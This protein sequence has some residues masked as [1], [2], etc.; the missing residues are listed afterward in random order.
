MGNCLA[1]PLPLFVQGF[2]VTYTAEDAAGNK[3]VPVVREVKVVDPCAPEQVMC[4]DLAL[5]SVLKQN[6]NKE[7]VQMFSNGGEEQ[8][9][10]PYVPEPDTDPPVLLFRGGCEAPACR[11]VTT[12]TGIRVQIHT[13]TVGEPFSEPGTPL[14][15]PSTLLM[16][17]SCGN[18]EKV[19]YASLPARGKPP[20][21]LL[22]GAEASDNRDG[23]VTHAISRLYSPG[24]VSTSSPTLPD[25]PYTI[26]YSVADLAGNEAARIARQVHVACPAGESICPKGEDEA[27]AVC[28]SDPSLCAFAGLAAEQGNAGTQEDASPPR[29]TLLGPKVVRITAGDGYRRCSPQAPPAEVCE[30]GASAADDVDGDLTLRVEV[31]PDP[32]PAKCQTHWRGQS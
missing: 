30:R 20:A 15:I 31:G 12:L 14:V 11:E 4:P 17:H 18:N 26:L 8:E 21:G 7:L 2:Q 10:E 25:S 28:A 27:P 32:L 22:A 3:A 13:L 16:P 23:N 6:C 1:A 5:C 9:P 24:R 29:L 19:A